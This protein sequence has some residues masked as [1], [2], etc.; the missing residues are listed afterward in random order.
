[1]ERLRD[2]I[3]SVQV[4]AICI[5]AGQGVMVGVKEVFPDVEHRECML[6]L[7]VNF[8]KKYHGKIF[9]DHL[10]QLLIHGVHTSSRSIGK[11]WMK[12]NQKQ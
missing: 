1:M 4:L 8:K 10:W 9:D 6:H 12:Q 3:G 5:D 2:A 11:Q 7:V